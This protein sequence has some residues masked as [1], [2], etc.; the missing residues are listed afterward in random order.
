[1][2]SNGTVCVSGEKRTRPKCDHSER[3]QGVHSNGTVYVV[4]EESSFSCNTD[5]GLVKLTC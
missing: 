5:L 1:M 3:S 4:I 2:H